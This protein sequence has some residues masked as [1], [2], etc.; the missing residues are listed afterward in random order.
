MADVL[1]RVERDEPLERALKRSFRLA[2]DLDNPARARIALG[3]HGVRCHL[4]RLSTRLEGLGLEVEPSTLWA[5]YRHDILEEPVELID[6]EAW[7]AVPWPEDPV[8]ALAVRRSLPS[9]WAASL[10]GAYGASDA[11]RLAEAL[12]RP[13]P[14]T[15][16]ARRSGREPEAARDALAERLAAEGQPSMPCQ[17]APA[18]LRLTER[19]PDIRGSQA[20][21]EGAY[22]VQDE[23]S[24]LVAEAVAARPGQ[25]ILDL[26][27]G[28]GGKTL[29]LAD[30]LQGTGALV[31]TDVSLA[32]LA[33]LRGRLSQRGFFADVQALETDRSASAQLHG[34]FDAILVDAPCSS[35][36][37]LRRGPDRKW[38]VSERDVAGLASLQL[39]LLTDIHGLLA[40]GGRLVYATCTLATAENHPVA[41]RF[42]A[43]APEMVPCPV[44]PGRPARLEL[45][46]DQ[47]DTDGFFIAAWTRS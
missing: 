32:R 8:E 10:V 21:R 18:G 15:V 23:G 27:A 24:Q 3:V 41:D 16:R 37:T 31:A 43:A 19:R 46:P 28:A 14:V 33:D 20:F 11:N 39:D 26:C 45:R 40:P 17:L 47:H 34:P 42:E 25:R 2:S 12:A 5:A 44:L 38:R 36:G 35:L 29:A 1:T 6:P 22:E 4:R 9:W 30:A 13:G 7:A